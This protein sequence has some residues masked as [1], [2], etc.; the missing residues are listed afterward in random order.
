MSKILFLEIPLYI[1]IPRKTKKN[2]KISLTLNWYRNA[3]YIVSNVA[4][5]IFKDKI[6]K[7]IIWKSLKPIKVH[8]KIYWKRISDLDN[9]SWVATK[10]L[11]DA[12]VE[13]WFIESDDFSWITKNMYEVWWKDVKNPRFEV[14]IYEEDDNGHLFKF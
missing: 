6:K 11:Q 1:E 12:L 10:F 14:S 8:Y 13:E 9:W 2:K 4:K 3:H 5:K 7:D